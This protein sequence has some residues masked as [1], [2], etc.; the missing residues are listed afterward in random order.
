MQRGQRVARLVVAWV[1]AGGRAVREAVATLSATATGW[2]GAAI[3]EA[4]LEIWD[5]SPMVLVQAAIRLAAPAG[6][7]AAAGALQ[8]T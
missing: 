8:T 3:F 7:R 6:T 4:R 2:W 1:A 5:L